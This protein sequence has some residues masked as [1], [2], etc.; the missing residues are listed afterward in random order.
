MSPVVFKVSGVCDSH[1]P[2]R[3]LTFIN[4]KHCLSVLSAMLGFPDRTHGKFLP[5]FLRLEEISSLTLI[6]LYVI[7]GSPQV[8]KVPPRSY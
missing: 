6:L 1:F 7:S 8:Q 3:A 2:E 4:V 5:N